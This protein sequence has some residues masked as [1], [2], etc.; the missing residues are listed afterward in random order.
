MELLNEDI[1]KIKH[2]W[3]EMKTKDDLLYLLNLVKSMIY[4]NNVKTIDAQLFHYFLN[5]D[6]SE[7]NYKKFEVKKKSGGV[8]I[9]LA[10]IKELKS[11]QR[12]LNV[13]FQFLFDPHKDAYGFVLNKSIKD[14]ALNH[15]KKNY[16][17]NIDLKDFFHS[18]DR[19]RVATEFLSKP[20]FLKVQSKTVA[21][22]VASLC[23]I[24]INLNGH[25]KSILPQGSPCSPT[26]TNF[27]C[28]TLDRRLKGLANRFGADYSRYADD[29][30]FS[31]IHN[32]YKDLIFLNELNRIITDQGLLINEQKTR[33]IKKYFKQEVTGLIVNEKVNVRRRYVKQIRVW[34]Y[35]WETYGYD[36]AEVEFLKNYIKDKGHLAKHKPNLR[37]V[38]S[39]KLEFLCMIKSNKDSTYIKLK[40]RFD[41]LTVN[42]SDLLT[43]HDKL[44]DFFEYFSKQKF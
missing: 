31:S 16:V 20:S 6:N 42:K 29:I 27:L 14:N 25:K 33:L 35:Y 18:F 23:T 37:Q 12:I 41:N 24:Q 38:L 2:F 7:L 3:F 34:L 43:L 21:L 32:L 13:I 17:Y 30:T 9:I 36:R 44:N 19:N 40:E 26:I 39:G 5:F 11:I 4:G 28:F 15:I 10:P 22:M 1:D 8:R